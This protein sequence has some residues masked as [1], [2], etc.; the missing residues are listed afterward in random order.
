MDCPAD[1]LGSRQAF[2][3]GFLRTSPQFGV[4]PRTIDDDQVAAVSERTLLYLGE[5][6][7]K[8]MPPAGDLPETS[9][10]PQETPMLAQPNPEC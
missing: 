5:K 4:R 8:F 2:S 3:Q 9:A 6:T 10:P 7:G 1:H